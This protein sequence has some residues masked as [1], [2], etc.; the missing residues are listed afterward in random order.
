MRLVISITT[1]TGVK[2]T[3]AIPRAHVT[4]IF[5]HATSLKTRGK[6]V[7][8][9]TGTT[10]VSGEV[11]LPPPSFTSTA[12]TPARKVTEALPTGSQKEP[13]QVA[14]NGMPNFEVFQIRHGREEVSAA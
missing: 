10:T 7:K 8:E 3:P 2:T 1:T 14:R 4:V 5:F 9:G 12:E 11:P 13:H 6:T